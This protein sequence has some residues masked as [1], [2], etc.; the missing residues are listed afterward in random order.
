M[1]IL[2][3]ATLLPFPPDTG[4]KQDTLYILRE[5]SRAGD[6][7]TAGVFFHESA[8]P[9]IPGEFA[10]LVREVVFLPG[11]PKPLH[12]RLLAS[13]S[14]EVPFKF[15]KYFSE[16]SVEIITGLL[17][18]ASFELVMLD[19][20]HLAPLVLSCRDN[21]MSKGINMPPLV[22]RTP[23]VESVVVEKYAERVDNPLV[24]T[25]AAREARKT[26][27]YEAAVLGEFD[28]VAAISPVDQARYRGMSTRPDRII[29][30]TAGVDVQALPPSDD[31]PKPGEV[32]FVGSFDWQP[33]VDGAK[34]LIDKVWPI[35]NERLPA[36]HLTLV[37]RK[38]PPY[39]EKM[40]SDSVSLTG[41]VDSVEEYVR[42]AC[43]CVV[44]LWIGSGM[45]LKIL[46]A[47]ALGRAVVSTSLGAE[48][49]EIEDG[50]N[51]LIRDEP[52][53]FADAVIEVLR[54][55][56]LRS[57]LGAHARELVEKKY[58]WEMSGRAFRDRVRGLL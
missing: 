46:E 44:P 7:I 24:K 8:P 14:D 37:G 12:S 35:I 36:A 58:S 41:W 40:A 49:I 6:D 43:C 1:R 27:A 15:R 3:L 4:G 13:L 25:F 26:K 42:R 33:N 38:P 18:S 54:D 20:L 45:R 19:H 23:N 2:W 17:E 5:F 34:W 52:R 51:I 47:F 9:D 48:G 11:N 28:L 10:S 22:L 31:P 32:V 16:E 21:L 56:K 53:A 50:T 29:C 39:L 55:D 57:S 30:I